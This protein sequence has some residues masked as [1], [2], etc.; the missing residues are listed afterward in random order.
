MR[1]NIRKKKEKKSYVRLGYDIFGVDRVESRVDK[2]RM[3]LNS[4][5]AVNP[6]S[7]RIA[8]VV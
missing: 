3:N 4:A 1:F 6:L 5:Q 7:I 2:E 8:N